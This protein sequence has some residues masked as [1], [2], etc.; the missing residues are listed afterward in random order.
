MRYTI[1]LIALFFFI[2]C[3]DSSTK[4]NDT[5][6]TAQQTIQ[7]PPARPDTIF[8][9]TGTEPFWA[10]YVINSSKIVFHPA[11][12]AD[13][14]VPFAAP[15]VPDSITANYNSASADAAIDLTITRKECSDGMS[16]IIYPYSVSLTVN[17]S[18]YTGCGKTKE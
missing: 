6:D 10:V 15:S 7:M 12:G 4:T 13:V 1:L 18:K 17:G 11:E 3:N 8:T 5:K 14:E 9:G 2:A 16:E